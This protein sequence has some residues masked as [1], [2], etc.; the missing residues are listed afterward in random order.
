MACN[1]TAIELHIGD[2][3]DVLRQFILTHIVGNCSGQNQ[4]EHGLHIGVCHL[5]MAQSNLQLLTK[6]FAVAQIHQPGITGECDVVVLE[7]TRRT[8]GKVNCQCIR[9]FQSR[10][11]GSADAD[12]HATT[13]VSNND[14]ISTSLYHIG[15]SFPQTLN[16]CIV[17]ANASP[18]AVSVLVY[19][20]VREERT[21]VDLDLTFFQLGQELTATLF[22]MPQESRIVT[23]VGTGRYGFVLDLIP[24]VAGHLDLNHIQVLQELGLGFAVGLFVYTDEVD[25]LPCI[26]PGRS[27]GRL[28]GRQPLGEQRNA[29]ALLH[30]Q[31]VSLQ[32]FCNDFQYGLCQLGIQQTPEIIPTTILRNETN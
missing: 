17:V 12:S 10:H 19:N 31:N 1:S 23:Q 16:S 27:V 22:V 21:G 20:V 29:F 30:T 3:K 18:T 7:L 6:I 5:G 9:N 4:I 14:G 13:A 32:L 24:A 25:D 28:S 26:L 8:L 15:E 11:I 2:D